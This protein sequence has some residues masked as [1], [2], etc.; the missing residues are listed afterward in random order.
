[1]PVI[2][3][4]EVVLATY[5]DHPDLWE[6]DQPL[7]RALEARGVRWRAVPWRSDHAD[8][9]RARAVV[10]R[11]TWDY[12]RHH[13]QYL[14]WA[15]RVAKVTRLWNPIEVVRWNTHK[16][17]MLE[18]AERGIPVTPT[19]LVPQGAAADLA[20]ILKERAW[21]RAVAK[22]AVSADSWE[23]FGVDREPTEE[24][25]L[26]F[27]RLVA[28]RDMLVQCFVASV[29]TSG[30]RCLV[31]IDGEVSHA[32]RKRSLFQGG[33]WTGPEGVPVPIERDE[34]ELARRVLDAAGARS[35]PYG[36]ID[37]ARDDSG[38]P[39]LME[40]ELSEPTLFLLDA[41]P[42]AS[43]RLADALLR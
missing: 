34:L 43:E 41:P 6:D 13:A 24:Q 21:P 31:A 1:M 33:R 27:A 25:R 10:L 5:D 28:E 15:D 39:L 4:G 35:L 9:S 30:E 18:L 32:V 20:L 19:V 8:W 16:G 42:A 17:Y 2:L 40:L 36:R 11:S 14:D 22:P 37:M 3:D 23:T 7:A 12:F 38:H 29:E 26:H